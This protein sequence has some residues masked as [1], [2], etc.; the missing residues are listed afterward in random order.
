[1]GFLVG[2]KKQRPPQVTRQSSL[3]SEVVESDP[4]SRLYRDRR[5]DRGRAQSIKAPELG[6]TLV[7][8]VTGKR[9]KLG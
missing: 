5:R 4:K 1:M 8:D 6:S 7:S 9:E 2:G 3:V